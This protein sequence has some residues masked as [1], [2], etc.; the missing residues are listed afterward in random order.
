MPQD[1]Y[2]IK[3]IAKELNH[4][5]AGGKI[6]KINQPERDELSLIIYTKSG[7]LKLEISASPKFCRVSLGRDDKPNPKVA[8][9]F[10]ML[11]RKH[12][13]NAEILGLEQIGFERIIRFNLKCFSEF[14]VS[15]MQL[16]CE[17]MGKY[18]NVILVEKGKILG[19]MKTTS[20]EENARRVLFSGAN[21]QLPASQGKTNPTD[22]CA[23]EAAFE[24]AG[25]ITAE[26]ISSAITGVAYT[27]AADIIE[28]YG[29]D[30]KAADV[31][32]YLSDESTQPCITFID[33]EM[34]DFKVKCPDGEKKLYPTLL[35]AQTEFYSCAYR[36][37]SFEDKKRQLSGA[38]SSSLKKAEKRLAQIDGKLLEC[39]AADEIKLKGELIT[40]NIY[41]IERGASCF[42]AVNYYLPDCPKI[43]IELDRQ[44]TPAQNA[45]KYYKKYAK[46]KRTIT[47]L[48]AQRQET[49]ERLDY[50][51]S[52]K[53]NIYAADAVDD[54][55]ETEEELNA[56]GLIKKAD[57]KKKKVD[58]AAPCRSF[59]L[60]GFKILCG[61]NNAQNDRLTKSL[62]PEDIWLHTQKY[63]SSHAA[64]I[65]EGRS[66]P[67][68]VLLTAAQICAYY[69]EARER[70]KVPVDYALKKF[71]KK[72]PKSNLGLAIYTDYKT[73]IVA[74]DAH[75]ELKEDYE[76]E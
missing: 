58:E 15:E 30:I 57:T 64:I 12:L 44:L 54:L 45:Q 3:F 11:L 7:T 51:N 47:A 21:Y 26:M 28:E 68:G 71:V 59:M 14:S 49:V 22:I 17:I 31:Y 65:T 52:I 29:R 53:G 43:K 48:T 24:G 10:C 23:V 32:D 70:D 20:L 50:L 19:A 18:S 5:L 8:P 2:T 34:K 72:P 6:C 36:K 69:S 41:A 63:H 46:L 39:E 9:N 55:T 42:E 61:R 37:K 76:R 4:L 38:L 75:A 56:L 66:V 40:A 67:D 33:G 13:Q 62:S 35:Q 1:A 16:Y 27:T 74:P 25:S 73:I 60:D